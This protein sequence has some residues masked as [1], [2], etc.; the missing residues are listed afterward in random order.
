MDEVT[1]DETPLPCIHLRRKTMY[2]ASA[3]GTS[4]KRNEPHWCLKTMRIY[5]P[6]D[7]LVGCEE[8]AEGRECYDP[9][10]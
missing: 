6:D 9:G 4:D 7:K 8:C 1:W 2:I 3:P 10:Y 5:G